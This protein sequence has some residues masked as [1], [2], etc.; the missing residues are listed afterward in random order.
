MN[1]VCMYSLYGLL[2]LL[3]TLPA[4]LTDDVWDPPD[5]V[6]A[7]VGAGWNKQASLA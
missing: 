4:A 6:E 3:L 5:W 2:L 7:G 1:I